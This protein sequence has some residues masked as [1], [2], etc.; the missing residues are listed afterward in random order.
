MIDAASV[1][2][3]STPQFSSGVPYVPSVVGKNREDGVMPSRAQRCMG[4]QRNLGLSGIYP[5]E[6]RLRE[7]DRIRNPKPEDRPEEFVAA[8]GWCRVFLP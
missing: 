6:L 8:R 4:A 3:L 1:V 7:G 5:L 2:F